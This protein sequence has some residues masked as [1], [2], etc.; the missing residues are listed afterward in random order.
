MSNINRQ[1][2]NTAHPA[3][4][5]ELAEIETELNTKILTG[6]AKVRFTFVLRTEAEQ[7][8]LWSQGRNNLTIT[9]RL[10]RQAN[11]APITEREN[12][13]IV[14]NAKPWESCHNYGFAVDICLMIDGKEAS[15]DIVA[16]LDGDGFSDWMEV[17]KCFKSKGWV[18]GGDWQRF[19]DYP[20]FEKTFGL[21][22][23]QMKARYDA[24]KF[25]FGTKYIV[26]N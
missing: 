8:A 14:T 7:A 10:R 5:A 17:V 12:R 6:R 21:S 2:I 26:I 24:E 20:H 18:W 1:R 22:V 3:L 11:M 25:V 23:K 15:Y 13:R 4:R 16:D 19:K 9:N